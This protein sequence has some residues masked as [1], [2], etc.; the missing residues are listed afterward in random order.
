MPGMNGRDL[1]LRMAAIRPG[2]RTLFTSGYTDR[3]IVHDG[4]LEP[5]LNFLP[6]PYTPQSLAEKARA[7]LDAR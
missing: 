2:L 5:G 6:K 3:G 7:V 4:L 1:A